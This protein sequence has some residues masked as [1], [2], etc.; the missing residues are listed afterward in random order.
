[1]ENAHNPAANKILPTSYDLGLT[2]SLWAKI[3]NEDTIFDKGRKSQNKSIYLFNFFLNQ[4]CNNFL[5]IG[6]FFDNPEIY[7]QV[8]SQPTCLMIR[9]SLV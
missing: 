4:K 6:M 3:G 8:K 2:K 9:T 1:M 5:T 7:S